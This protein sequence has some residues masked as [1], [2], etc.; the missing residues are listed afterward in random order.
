LLTSNACAQPQ[1]YYQVPGIVVQSWEPTTNQVRQA[2]SSVKHHCKVR[3]SDFVK[4]EGI[5]PDEIEIEIVPVSSTNSPK[6]AIS[7]SYTNS[8]PKHFKVY[9]ID[10][11]KFGKRV[12]PFVEKDGDGGIRFIAVQHLLSQDIRKDAEESRPFTVYHNVENMKTGLNTASTWDTNEEDGIMRVR[13]IYSP[14]PPY[15][16]GTARF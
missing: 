16:I 12:C 3:M 13:A 4:S 2:L 5:D 8:I 7:N 11:S 15:H 1:K 10:Y 9:G 6:S 14:G